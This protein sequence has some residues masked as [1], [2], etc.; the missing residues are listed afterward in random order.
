MRHQVLGAHRDL[1]PEPPSLLAKANVP[2]PYEPQSYIDIAVTRFAR[3]K[4]LFCQADQDGACDT[5]A[6][7]L[8]DAEADL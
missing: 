3:H 4:D 5:E 7:G 2:E 8:P 1:T 6:R